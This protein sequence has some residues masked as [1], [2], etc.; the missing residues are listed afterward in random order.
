MIVVLASLAMTAF[1]QA[2]DIRII[3]P[4]FQGTRLV[5]IYEVIDG[6]RTAG[7]YVNKKYTVNGF[8]FDGYTDRVQ[9]GEMFGTIIFGKGTLSQIGCIANGRIVASKNNV[10]MTYIN[11]S[12]VSCS[13]AFSNV[14]LYA[15][16]N[17]RY[18][19][20]HLPIGTR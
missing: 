12:W 15:Y 10:P 8:T 3:S 20:K 1:A 17:N 18:Y 5:G 11:V 19:S 16:F 14:D 9:R 7:M 2:Q 6:S 13:P 4:R